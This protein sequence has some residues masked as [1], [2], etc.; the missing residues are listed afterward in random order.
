[1]QKMMQS[2]PGVGASAHRLRKKN[3]E[4]ADKKPMWQKIRT[5]FQSNFYEESIYW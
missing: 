2:I 1:M 5:K 4:K 3:K